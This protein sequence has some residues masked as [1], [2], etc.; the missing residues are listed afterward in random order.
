MSEVKVLLDEDEMPRRWYNIQSDLPAKL[1]PPL[2][3]CTHEPATHDDMLALFSSSLV[4]QE[5]STSRY[6][7]IPDEVLEAYLRLGRPTPLCRA[8]RLEGF[9]KTPAHIFYKR[10]DVSF[11][12]SHKTNTAIAQAYY[13]SVQFFLAH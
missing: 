11:A 3:P 2:N 8:K 10:E 5:V 1:P 7:D 6:I 12:G 13:S 9:L 4:K